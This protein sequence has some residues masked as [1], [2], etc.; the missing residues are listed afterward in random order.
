LL[1]ACKK[2]TNEWWLEMKYLGATQLTDYR[3]NMSITIKEDNTLSGLGI[4]EVRQLIEGD[5]TG[6]PECLAGETNGVRVRGEIMVIG[7]Y[8]DEKILVESLEPTG[9]PESFSYIF[10]CAKNGIERDVKVFNLRLD[11][12]AGQMFSNYIIDALYIFSDGML[13]FPMDPVD[14]FSDQDDQGFSFILHQGKMPESEKIP[15]PYIGGE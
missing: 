15:T 9:G 4:L 13:K 5:L 11:T 1:P 3:L 14:E 10:Y 12:P 8:R 6:Y 2:Q 7:S